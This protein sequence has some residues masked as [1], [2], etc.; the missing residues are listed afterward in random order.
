MIQLVAQKVGNPPTIE[1][2]KQKSKQ[3]V[4]YNS[5]V[6]YIKIKRHQL[7]WYIIKSAT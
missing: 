2:C 5:N 7:S 6:I 3:C 4:V 1:K